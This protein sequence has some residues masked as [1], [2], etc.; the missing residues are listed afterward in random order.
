ML[1]RGARAGSGA[2]RP[3]N[4]CR[5]TQHGCQL[6]QRGQT[7]RQTRARGKFRDLAFHFW[8]RVAWSHNF[9]S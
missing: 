1:A 8:R 3:A 6:R 2:D 5:A 7:S 4:Q 9:F